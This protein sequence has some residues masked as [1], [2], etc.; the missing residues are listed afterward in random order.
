MDSVS[1]IT[2]VE[3]TLSSM[4][5]ASPINTPC[6]LLEII[7]R[8]NLLGHRIHPG[9]PKELQFWTALYVVKSEA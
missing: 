3:A 2:N 8:N 5:A 1:P 9:W 7:A 4:K 6:L